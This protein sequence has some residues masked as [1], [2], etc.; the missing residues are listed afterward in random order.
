[1]ITLLFKTLFK[2]SLLIFVIAALILSAIY[3]E[4][5]RTAGTSIQDSINKYLNLKEEKI[6]LE[7]VPKTLNPIQPLKDEYEPG[8]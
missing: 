7:G 3:I 6:E 1:M 8:C 4:D 2:A 5:C